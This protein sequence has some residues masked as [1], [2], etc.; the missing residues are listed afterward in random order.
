MANSALSIH[1]MAKRALATAMDLGFSAAECVNFI[2]SDTRVPRYVITFGDER[3]LRRSRLRT[4]QNWALAYTT[5]ITCFRHPQIVE[6][7]ESLIYGSLKDFRDYITSQLL[8]VIPT[9]AKGVKTNL[10]IQ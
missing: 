6:I 7:P 1:E 8:E 10:E 2:D 4:P 3:D 5:E 9:D